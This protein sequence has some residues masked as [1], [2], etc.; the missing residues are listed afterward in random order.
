MTTKLLGIDDAR[1]IA[2][3]LNKEGRKI[4]FCCGNFDL[5]HLGHAELLL[6]TKQRCEILFVAVNSDESV[7]K[8]KGKTRPF[9]DEAGRANMVACMRFVDYVILNEGLSFAG[10]IEAVNP[11]VF[12]TTTDHGDSPEAKAA[13]KIGSK[14]EVID[15]IPGYGTT[16]IANLV[17]KSMN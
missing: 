17:S 8:K 9:V 14:V 2:M 12:V 3:G 11:Q 1:E 13:E 16:R 5:I 6:Q 15:L 10:V 4:G 7:R